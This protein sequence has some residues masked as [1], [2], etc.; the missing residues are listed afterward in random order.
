MTWLSSAAS[1]AGK[2]IG[3]I[4]KGAGSILSFIPAI[5]PLVGPAVMVA[6][7]ALQAKK[8]GTMDI[9]TA[10]TNQLVQSQAIANNMTGAGAATL[11]ASPLTTWIKN[12]LMIVLGIVVIAGYFLL[13]RKHRR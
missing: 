10:A 4:V 6:G 3:N 13:K 5:G 1:W 12:N 2:N 11:S 9:V 8:T 7:G